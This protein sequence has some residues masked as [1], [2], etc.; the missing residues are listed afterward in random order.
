MVVK[1]VMAVMA[2]HVGMMLIDGGRVAGG[3][4][5]GAGAT[6]VHP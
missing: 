3:G 6:A 5:G 4:G 1:R 2:V